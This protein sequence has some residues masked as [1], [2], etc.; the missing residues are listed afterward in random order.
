MPV[1]SQVR[2]E[3]AYIVDENG[4]SFPLA[5]ISELDSEL[6]GKNDTEIKLFETNKP[7]TIQLECRPSKKFVCMMIGWK[8]KGPY[9]RRL[10]KRLIFWGNK[11]GN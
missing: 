2:L 10:M 9:R 6:D 8:A 4:I 5:E 11:H 7:I 3:D 1:K